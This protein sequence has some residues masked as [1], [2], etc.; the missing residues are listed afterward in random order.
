MKTTHFPGTIVCAMAI[1]L[2]GLAVMSCR[3]TVPR[4]A[5]AGSTVKEEMPGVT[6]PEDLM[7]E[8]G[9]LRRVLLI[10]Q[11]TIRRIDANQ[12]VPWAA[13]ASCADIVRRFVEDYHEKLEE[14]YIFP[15]F[16]AAGKL[17]DLTTTLRAQHKAG[18]ALTDEIKRL[19]TP[20]RGAIKYPDSDKKLA[21]A[22]RKFIAMYQVHAA[23][24]DTVLFPAIRDVVTPEEFD[25]M[26]D[27]FEDK[28]NELFGERGFEKVVDQVA[29]IEKTLGIYDLNQFTPTP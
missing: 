29:D 1:L 12:Q 24:E 23:R 3:G 25:K 11:E 26:G 17:V 6:A 21:D 20:G 22:L 28:E 16:E 9:V 8:H 10:Y 14:D 5:D 7:R 18:R 13:V 4:R 2:A 27:Q 19:S 15:K